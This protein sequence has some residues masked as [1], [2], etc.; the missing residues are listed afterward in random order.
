MAPARTGRR[1]TS[2]V[3]A[4][5]K[6]ASTIT[7]RA[8]EGAAIADLGTIWMRSGKLK[9][10]L[11]EAQ[12]GTEPNTGPLAA[13]RERQEVSMAQKANLTLVDDKY[14]SGRLE[15]ER[16]DRE[17]HAQLES[18]LI[19]TFQSSDPAPTVEHQR[20]EGLSF[21]QAVKTMFK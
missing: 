7:L 3:F 20:R 21:W 13:V 2:A 4:V 5:L 17:V 1:N 12:H 11:L 15:A 19:D 18:G 16:R 9:V 8:H 6:S 10:S 14:D